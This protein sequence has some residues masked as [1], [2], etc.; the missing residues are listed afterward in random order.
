MTPDEIAAI[1][2]KTKPS[3][4]RAEVGSMMRRSP[5]VCVFPFKRGGG[6]M[7]IVWK[8]EPSPSE[9]SVTECIA[10]GGRCRSSNLFGAAREAVQ[11]LLREYP[12][13][14]I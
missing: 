11:L 2:V 8:P 5:S 13:P 9:A 4:F 14:A 12:Q 6:Y 7:M 1:W 3:V 10:A